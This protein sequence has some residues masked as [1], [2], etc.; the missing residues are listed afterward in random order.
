VVLAPGFTA[1][2]GEA[3]SGSGGGRTRLMGR[4]VSRRRRRHGSVEVAWP[5]TGRT[6]LHCGQRFR[7]GVC[8][9]LASQ[10]IGNLEPGSFTS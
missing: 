10:E 2:S 8:R 4:E 9:C 1:T 5:E 7:G 3:D 6:S